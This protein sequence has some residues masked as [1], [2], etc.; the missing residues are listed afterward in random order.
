[1]VSRWQHHTPETR[2]ATSRRRRSPTTSCCGQPFTMTPTASSHH[3]R[4]RSRRSCHEPAWQ[5]SETQGCKQL[6]N[7]GRGC[8]QLPRRRRE[9]PLRSG[10]GGVQGSGMHILRNGG[11]TP[12][13]NAGGRQPLVSRTQLSRLVSS[14]VRQRRTNNKKQKKR[15][16]PYIKKLT[17]IKRIYT[18]QTY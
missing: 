11:P 7:P 3:M 6:R 10:S 9:P 16:K 13:A 4:Y 17:H 2:G 12:T 18:R 14:I 15:N 5:Q 1:M 8:K